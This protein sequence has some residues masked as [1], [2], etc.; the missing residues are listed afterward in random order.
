MENRDN[1]HESAV[2][3][4]TGEAVYVNDMQMGN[5]LTGKVVFSTHAH[6]VI[7]SCDCS[8]ALAIEGV[9][10]I[11]KAEDIPGE[12]QMGPV[13]HDEPCLTQ[14]E[15]L[16]IGQ[17]I[18]LI[19]ADSEEIARKAEKKIKINYAPLEA[20]TD[21]RTAIEKGSFFAP[22][23][24][25]ASGD[26]D[27][28]WY[29][30]DYIIEGELETGGQEHWYLETQTALCIPGE[31]NEMLVYA[32][33]QHPSETQAIVAG[34]LGVQRNEVE[35]EVKR[36]GGGFGGKETQ[37]N[38]VAAWAALLANATRR[39][40]KIHLNRQ[41]DQRI[42]GKRHPFLSFYKAGFNRDGRIL[43]ADIRLFA[44]GGYAT[45]LSHAIMQRALFHADNAYYI[46]NFRVS[47]TVCRTHQ[48]SNTAFR[49]FGGPQGMVVAETIIDR[50]ARFLEKDPLDI[51]KL[52]FY[53]NNTSNITPYG[54]EIKNN[55]LSVLLSGILG[56]SDYLSRRKEV[57]RFN[58]VNKYFKKGIAL[59]PV[60]FGISFTTSFLNQAGA[61]VHI[62]RDGSILVNHGGTE[63]GQG[64]HTKIKQIAAA[65]LGISVENVKVNAT[66]TSQV[67]NTSATAASSG[68]DL[69]GMAVR[70]AIDTLKK[71][72][73]DFAC[74]HF[75]KKFKGIVPMSSEIVF[76]DNAV[77]CRKHS[78]PFAE[79]V[80]Q[81][82]LAQISLSSTGYYCT[83]DIAF[84]WEQGRGTP[85]YYFTFGMSVSEVLLDLLTGAVT[86]LRTD[87]LHDVGNSIN[88]EV[89][90][91]QIRGGFIQGVGWCTQE[92]LKWD[93]MGNLLTCS[94]DTYKIPG[95][96]DIPKEFPVTLLENT[97]HPSTI[98][99]SK[100]VGEPPFMHCFSVWLAIKDAISAVADHQFEPMFKIPATNEFII[101]SIEDLKNKCSKD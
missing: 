42:T 34:V 33:S 49:G 4:V 72:L 2:Q 76:A 82:Y 18:A 59:T 98:R 63:M 68:T 61:L 99:G 64:L 75:C 45:D 91:G 83:P 37:A 15:V 100:A 58:A 46:P 95:V 73:S 85:F 16:C 86:L 14:G 51:R 5:T 13:V 19:A 38:H 55:H 67:P 90:K 27:S 44:N 56:S 20:I 96:R 43:V 69:N 66:N 35:V 6:A 93:A 36:M 31:G 77:S 79:L 78:I 48:P 62:Y 28:T 32:S 47:G 24:T 21:L 97:Y 71:R 3:H 12:N 52:N 92:E 50:I 57:E 80:E 1:I 7:V 25:I 81:A 84:N 88:P 9:R 65:E 70:A 53:G 40:V 8:E 22:P 54:E 41:D 89:D 29:A 30:C 94:P 101:E 23:L 17:A 11:I 26:V 39:P 87:I 10:A 74:Q 60:K